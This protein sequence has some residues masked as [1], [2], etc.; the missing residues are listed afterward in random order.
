MSEA[1]TIR[2][3]DERI[4][5]YIGSLLARHDEPV[6]LEME[7][8]ARERGF[9]IVGRLVGASLEVLARSVGARRVFEFGSGYGY[10]AYWFT[11]AVGADGKVVCTE[12]SADNVSLAKGFLERVGRW[13]RTEYHNAW[14]QDVFKSTSDEYDV[15]YNDADKDAYPEI[16]DLARTRVRRGGLYI[17]DNTLWS[18]RVLDSHTSDEWTLAIW[19]HNRRIAADADFD[20]FL[21]PTRDG[22]IVARRK[23]P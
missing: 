12:G 7:A 11:R 13:D 14:A 23:D 1:L 5:D 4:E 18:G 3:V 17:C 8:L 16:W 15:I 6:L 2:P 20:F 9:P 22:V 19:E 21:N 10:S